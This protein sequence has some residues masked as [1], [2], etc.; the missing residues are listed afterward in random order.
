MENKQEWKEN[1]VWR[2][3]EKELSYVAT[4]A[5]TERRVELLRFLKGQFETL[6]K[7]ELSRVEQE[8]LERAMGVVE[9]YFVG[10]IHVPNPQ[11]TKDSIIA[12]IKGISRDHAQTKD[13]N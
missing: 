3:I 6:L 1:K 10:L 5:N 9:D 11:A 8:T 4:Y 2:D 12:A 7:A 13:D